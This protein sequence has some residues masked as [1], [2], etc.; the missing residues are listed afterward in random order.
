MST[1][2][3]EKEHLSYSFL[4]SIC[5][6]VTDM[7]E[8]DEMRQS[9]EA[10]GFTG[11]SEYLIADNTTGTKFSAYEAIATFIKRSSAQYLI[12]VHQDVRCIDDNERL[13]D[14]LKN[15]TRIDNKWAICGNAGSMGY[16]EKRFYLENAGNQIITQGLPAEVTSLDEN[17]LIINRDTN[18]TLSADFTGFHLYGTDLCLVADFLGYKSYVIPFMV[19]HLSLGNMEEL[20][21]YKKNFIRQYG[22]KLRG[23]FIETTCTKFYLSNSELKNKLFNS[24]P[25]FLFIKLL[26]R[27]GFL[28]RRFALKNHSY[29]TIK[30]KAGTF[31]SLF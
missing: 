29:K 16:H 4:F 19:K 13:I 5:S 11:N 1:K 2:Q 9:F 27:I 26:Q 24:W 30:R 3:I 14:C 18:L 28:W 17:L 23:R 7:R 15:L 8:Y 10:C 22:K 21:A 20:K 31:Q 6:I 25:V 12:L